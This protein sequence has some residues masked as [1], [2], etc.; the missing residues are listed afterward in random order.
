MADNTGLKECRSCHDLKPTEDFAVR[1][2]TVRRT[3][4]KSCLAE[5]KRSY[6]QKNPEQ[7]QK[8]IEISR[9]SRLK[10][11]FGITQDEYEC[12]LKSQEGVCAIC[13]LGPN[14]I[15]LAVD[16]NHKTGQVRGLLCITCNTGIG[17]FKDD[18]D[19]LHRGIFYLTER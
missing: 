10:R 8:H 18:P 9:N 19:L 3:Q 5:Y 15:R 13:K 12:L 7:Y 17:M 4:C 11:V 14:G 2:R 1:T 6:H 16:H